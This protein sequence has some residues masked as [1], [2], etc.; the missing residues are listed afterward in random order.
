[1]VRVFRRLD[2][3][4]EKIAE[5]SAHLDAAV[6]VDAPVLAD[7]DAAGQSALEDETRVSAETSQR[8]A[9][10]ANRVVMQHAR[11]GRVVEDAARTRT[12]PSALRRA[13]HHRDPGCRFPGCDVRFGQGHH[14][15]KLLADLFPDRF[16]DSVLGESPAGW[17]V[18]SLL[19]LGKL[20]SGG[21]PK[22]DRPDYWNGDVAWPVPRTFLSVASP[23][24]SGLNERSHGEACSTRC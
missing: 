7:A 8:L 23:S 6:H 19:R 10:D 24:S 11:D 9:C 12:I 13:L 18:G 5:L 22:T 15:P 2:C 4:G 14:I 1:M 21:T 20:L 16:E 17:A 3:L